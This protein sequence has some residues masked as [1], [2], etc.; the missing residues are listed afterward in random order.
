MVDLGADARSLA[1]ANPEIAEASI[2]GPGMS[3]ARPR[4]P[5]VAERASDPPVADWRGFHDALRHA[6]L[7]ATQSGGPLSLLLLELA[8]QARGAPATGAERD[9]DPGAATVGR[10]AALAGEIATE[11]GATSALARYA[12]QRLAVIMTGIDLG[13]AVVRAEQIGRSLSSSGAGGPALPAI[14][15]AQFRD[16]EPLGHLIE[17]ATEALDRARSDGSPIAVA[18]PRARRAPGACEQLC[19]CGLRTHA[20]LCKRV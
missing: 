8:G 14:G 19:P 4:S 11:L 18:R 3:E 6:A 1:A 17:R 20:C 2:A 10:I 9:L 12:E 15:V 13:D 7:A 5:A 16:D